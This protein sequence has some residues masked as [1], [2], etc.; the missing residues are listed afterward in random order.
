MT[1][2]AGPESAHGTAMR[3]IARGGAVT[4][5]GAIANAG[6]SLALTALVA[7][8]LSTTEAGVYFALT[9]MFLVL[10]GVSEFGSDVG[11]SRFIPHL[12]I[13]GQPADVRRIVRIAGTVSCLLGVVLGAVAVVW[14][15]LPQ[16]AQVPAWLGDARPVA[17]AMMVVLPLATLSSTLLSAMRGHSRMVPVAALG[18]TLRPA[19]Q[20]GLS[21]V[22]VAVGLASVGPMSLAFAIPFAL[23][24]LPA[25]LWYRSIARGASAGPA[26]PGAARPWP[27]AK[28]Y[29]AFTWPRAL[30]RILQILVQR[31]DVVLV[32]ILASPA[33]AAI[34]TVAT[35]AILLGQFFGSAL[36]QILAPQVSGLL[37]READ[38]IARDVVKS[39][40]LLAVMVT[41]PVYLLC[42]SMATVVLDALGGARYASG[43]TTLALMGCAM[44]F[45]SFVGAADTLL[46]MGGRS[47]LS[48]ANYSVAFVVDLALL[49][50]L[51]P[52]LGSLGAAIAWASAVVTRNALG[53]VQV[54]RRNGYWTMNG[55]AV[56]VALLAVGCFLVVPLLLG[57]WGMGFG[58]KA[59]AAV[60][61]A[62]AGYLAI[63]WRIRFLLPLGLTRSRGGFEGDRAAGAL[64]IGEGESRP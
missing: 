45:A 19:L 33:E 51:V 2:Q 63:L 48:L 34:Y 8:S 59:I 26:G 25:A 37:S 44:C 50:V 30:T 15:S 31:G 35:R 39:T 58:I 20:L 62:T 4:L 21:A 18:L 7:R 22:L 10:L 49:V 47:R 23:V 29:V 11:L 43:A 32:A 6:I 55:A 1:E 54:R 24:S 17:L 38:A 41:W 5:L 40:T 46:L 64:V 42:V 9:S 52:T 57:S 56:V 60:A 53:V 61:A 27:L 3:T 28:A 13:A 36:Q 16:G 14:S 12:T